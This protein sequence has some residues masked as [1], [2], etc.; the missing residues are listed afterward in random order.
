MG[1]K[2]MC[3]IDSEVAPVFIVSC[4]V[5]DIPVDWQ[6]RVYESIKGFLSLDDFHLVIA[7]TH[8]HAAPDIQFV[9]PPEQTYAET[10]FE[11]ILSVCR[12]AFQSKEMCTRFSFGTTLISDIGCIRRQGQR[13]AL[14]LTVQAFYTHSRSDKPQGII[15]HF[16]CHPTILGADNRWYSAEYPGVIA[17]RLAS[18]FEGACVCFFNGAAGDISARCTRREQTFREMERIGNELAERACRLIRNPDKVVGVREDWSFHAASREVLLQP[19]PLNDALLTTL[20]NSVKTETRSAMSSVQADRTRHTL[21]QALQAWRS[22][23]LANAKPVRV[24]V[25]AVSFSACVDYV[26]WPG[27]PFSN[28]A[29]IIQHARTHPVVLVGY[30][31]GVGYLPDVDADDD[32][33]YEV[34]MSQYGRAAGQRLLAASR[35]LLETW[36]RGEAWS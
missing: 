14:P 24:Q 15:V 31:G 17:S 22:G 28:Y 11:T 18:V 30:A 16:P 25:M 26:F 12:E 32:V 13:I 20:S 10:V 7:S 33:S 23:W 1:V 5:L 35:G 9:S 3:F 2:A 8:T 4:D 6:G 36:E 29:K 21:L 27:E 19:Q 34:L